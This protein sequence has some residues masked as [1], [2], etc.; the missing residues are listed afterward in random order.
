MQSYSAAEG[1]RNSSA[2]DWSRL[3]SHLLDTLYIT[4]DK[5]E[6][7]AAASLEDVATATTKRA[8]AAQAEQAAS[9][10]FGEMQRRK[11]ITRS[12]N[13]ALRPHSEQFSRQRA[14][15]DKAANCC[16]QLMQDALP[17]AVS[18]RLTRVRFIVQRCNQRT[19]IHCLRIRSACLW[20]QYA[21]PISLLPE[22]CLT[23]LTIPNIPAEMLSAAI[24]LMQKRFRQITDRIRK[25]ASRAG[26]DYTA[27]GIRKLEITYNQS[28]NDFH[29]HLHLVTDSIETGSRLV[30]EWLSRWPQA[31]HAAQD[32]RK[33]DIAS[34]AELFKYFTKLHTKAES[35]Y[36]TQAI[37]TMFCAIQS[38][39]VIQPFNLR[40]CV[41]MPENE[42]VQKEPLE[43]LYYVPPEIQRWKDDNGKGFQRGYWDGG[44]SYDWDDIQRDYVCRFDKQR[45]GNLELQPINTISA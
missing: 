33:A 43:F 41:D 8:D 5:T 13:R 29:P 28:R 19:C 23:T 20:K 40:A 3:G 39:R 9:L 34:L 31:S 25:E 18:D 15:Y 7:A 12:L 42:S 27:S 32:V 22:P 35:G 38:R 11:H 36:N 21:K 1:G 4:A 16:Q 30:D 2:A 37:H 24:D 45:L 44:T 14:A 26:R 17:E 6:T 10:R